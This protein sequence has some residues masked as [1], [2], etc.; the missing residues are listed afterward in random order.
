MGRRARLSNL[1]LLP[2]SLPRRQERWAVWPWGTH[3]WHHWDLA[4]SLAA[5]RAGEVGTG[6]DGTIKRVVE[7][8]E[9]E[10]QGSDQTNILELNP[11][12]AF[13]GPVQHVDEGIHCKDTDP[14][15]LRGKCKHYDLWSI[16]HLPSHGRDQR[17][18]EG[19]YLEE[20][21]IS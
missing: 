9:Q 7:R 21:N 4:A 20:L 14:K 10:L 6:E 12:N 5:V 13:G 2:L 8:V 3:G 19:N 16:A 15:D 17:R 11:P 1:S 18:G